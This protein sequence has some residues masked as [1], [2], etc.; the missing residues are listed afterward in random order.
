MLGAGAAL[1]TPA[2]PS[3]TPC[4]E[5]GPPAGTP[6][7]A[8]DVPGL[9]WATRPARIPIRARV[10]TTSQRRSLPRSE[11][12]ASRADARDADSGRGSGSMEGML[13]AEP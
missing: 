8:E 12:P 1:P 3:E 9:A 10:A 6:A 5:F 7:E 4:P 2:A 13:G 11:S